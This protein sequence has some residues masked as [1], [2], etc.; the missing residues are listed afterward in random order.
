MR[1]IL[2]AD[3]GF[4]RRI[5]EPELMDDVAQAAAYA[6]ADFAEPNRLFVD[7]FARSFPAFH[8]ECIVDLGCGPADIPIRFAR[9]Y[10]ACRVIGV[11]GAP[12]MLELGRAAVDEARLGQRIR[13]VLAHVGEHEPLPD[14]RADA[15]VSNSLLHH[16]A[17]PMVLWRALG[18]WGAPG[19]AVLV[20][21]LFRPPSREDA[22]A[23]VDSY[24]GEEPDILRRDFFNSL[25]AA[26]RPE[27]VRTQLAAA[28]LEHLRVETISDRHLT[29]CGRLR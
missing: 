18:Q 17:D 25:L 12:A 14:E 22:Q 20:M 11:D 15:V 21:D 3:N 28:G 19:A 1:K 26:Y 13:L 4:M 27:E 2:S 10:P 8:G 9:A 16:L 7:T 6:A 23:I 29:V 5:P 24:A